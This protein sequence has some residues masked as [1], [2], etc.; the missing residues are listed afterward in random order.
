MNKINSLLEIEFYLLF[1]TN[2]DK[3]KVNANSKDTFK[4]TLNKIFKEETFKIK[5]GILNGEKIDFNK[6]K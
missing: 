4:S 6:I 5:S 1:A 2:G 3:I